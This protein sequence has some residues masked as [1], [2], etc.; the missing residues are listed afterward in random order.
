[1]A[2]GFTM[3]PAKLRR[4]GYAT[5]QLGKVRAPAQ[6]QRCHH[7]RG[8]H[9]LCAVPND[10]SPDCALRCAQW[11]LGAIAPWM[12]PVARGFDSSLGFL[13]GAEDH[14]TQRP[15][16]RAFGCKGVDLWRGARGGAG[17][18]LGLGGGAPAY[19]LNGTGYGDFV[20]GRAAVALI[21]AHDVSVPMFL[22]M[23]T[24]VMHSPQQAPP[25][26]PGPAYLH[27]EARSRRRVLNRH[28]RNLPAG[29]APLLCA[30]PATNLLARLRHH[31]RHGGGGRR[32]AW[33]RD[34]CAPSEGHVGA[35]AAAALQ[36][37]WRPRGSPLLRPLGQ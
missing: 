37:Q 15:N 9:P 5:H 31:E 33:Q 24:Q 8:I 12:S 6:Q 13:A 26:R 10:N 34:L 20:Y 17:D 1:V 18:R 21:G 19:G 32:G 29:A 23:A 30:V 27:R 3:L 25:A 11:H 2:R 22:F 35:H 4:A 14:W 7:M 36:R 16:A 28:L